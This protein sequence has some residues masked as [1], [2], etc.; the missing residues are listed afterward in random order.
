MA[1]R[2]SVGLVDPDALNETELRGEYARLS[3]QAREMEA[4]LVERDLELVRHGAEVAAQEELNR[5][6]RQ[7][8]D[9]ATKDLD[10]LESQFISMERRLTRDETRASAVASLADAQLIYEKLRK[11]GKPAIGTDVLDDAAGK[12]A[13]AEDQMKRSNYAAAAYYANRASRLLNQTEERHNAFLA[14]GTA[15][16]VSVSSANLR[17]GPGPAFGVVGRL[18]YGTVLVEVESRDGWL[19][20]KTRDGTRGWIHNTLVY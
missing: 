11:D 18:I 5:L 19:L 2:S 12:I 17:L 1:P 16:V 6:L 13:S 10:F 4:T 20:V 9:A 3:V 15:R 8:L 14:G 7:E